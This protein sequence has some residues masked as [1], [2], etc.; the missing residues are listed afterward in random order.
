IGLKRREKAPKKRYASALA[1][2]EDLRRFLDRRPIHARP[3]GQVARAWRWARREP[4]TAALLAAIGV[5]FILI[6]AL[7]VG[8][9]T[10]L[11]TTEEMLEQNQQRIRAAL[12]AEKAANEAVQTSQYLAAVR[13]A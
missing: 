7:L 2:A 1:L 9:S 4:R 6:P 8:Y 10:R 5:L 11:N 12:K 3:V 13:E